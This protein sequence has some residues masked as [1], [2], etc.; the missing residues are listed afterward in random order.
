MVHPKKVPDER[1]VT[2]ASTSVRMSRQRSKD[3]GPELAVRRALHRQGHRYRVHIQPL[4][5]VRREADIV[6][7]RAKVAVFIDG[8]FWHRCPEH[9]TEPGRNAASWT[10]KLDRN[11]QRDHETDELLKQSGW[12]VIRVWE[13]E[14]AA[15]AAERIAA[16]VAGTRRG[17]LLTASRRRRG[18]RQSS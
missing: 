12:I 16:A 10:V 7:T 6:F 18:A 5:G 14:D 15:E 9:R 3:T 17:Q 2:D 13:H 4:K 11:A 8:C 1:F